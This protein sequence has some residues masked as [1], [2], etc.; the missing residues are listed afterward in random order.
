MNETESPIAQPAAPVPQNDLLDQV[1]ALRQQVFT[2]LLALVVV[3]GTLT[4]FLYIQARRASMELAVIKPQASAMI[5][6]FKQKQPTMETFVKQLTAY[7]V[8]HPDFQPIL[9]KYGIP[10][11]PASSP[12]APSAPAAPKK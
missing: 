12:V 6:A 1:V 11:P 4:V 5:D 8:T 3:S 2:L 10:L 9:K 7:G